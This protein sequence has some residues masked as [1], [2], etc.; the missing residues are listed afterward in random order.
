MPSNHASARSLARP[1]TNS[2]S[3]IFCN[4]RVMSSGGGPP[5]ESLDTSGLPIPDGGGSTSV[6]AGCRPFK[7]SFMASNERS[8]RASSG[9]GGGGAGGVG[10]ACDDAPLPRFPRV[11]T[12]LYDLT[13]INQSCQ[14]EFK[15]VSNWCYLN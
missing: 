7:V 8:M 2:G 6:P 12:I 11:L 14:G 13:C 4:S 15:D 9:D 1:P 5:P 3:L 10:G